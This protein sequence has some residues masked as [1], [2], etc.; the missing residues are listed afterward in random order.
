MAIHLFLG[1]MNANSITNFGGKSLHVFDFFYTIN[2]PYPCIKNYVSGKVFQIR[3]TVDNG[4]RLT[5]DGLP[6]NRKQPPWAGG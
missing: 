5:H 4:I 1:Q 3:T 6:D 2:I